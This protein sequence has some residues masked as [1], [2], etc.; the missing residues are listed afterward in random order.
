MD[1]VVEACGV[2]KGTLYR[3]FPSK[4]QLYFAVMFDG[5]QRLRV[6]LE[7]AVGTEE[8]PAQKVRRIVHRTLAFFWDRR[9]FFSLIH[10]GEHKMTGEAREWFRYRGALSRVIRETLEAAVAAG[11]VRC[12]DTRIA[13]EMLLGMMRGVNR[14]RADDDRLDDLVTAVVDVFMRGVGTRT[15]R[16]IVALRRAART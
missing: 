5:I 8:P 9:F 11:H 4:Q 10:R 7:A 2:G 3:Y 13:T 14:Y 16:R 1:D 15:G 6:E 12:I